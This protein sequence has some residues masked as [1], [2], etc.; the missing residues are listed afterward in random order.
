MLSVSYFSHFQNRKRRPVPR[1]YQILRKY[2]IMITSHILIEVPSLKSFSTVG[3]RYALC[4][5]NVLNI[6][7]FFF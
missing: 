3:V 6:Y 1:L 5:T 4:L 2:H 7:F